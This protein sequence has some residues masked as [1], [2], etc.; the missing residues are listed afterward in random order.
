MGSRDI[1]YNI[2]MIMLNTNAFHLEVC[3]CSFTVLIYSDKIRRNIAL[4][5]LRS[6]FAFVYANKLDTI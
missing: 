6:M 1:K 3:V 5:G 2:T 4:F